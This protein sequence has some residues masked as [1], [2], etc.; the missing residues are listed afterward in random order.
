MGMEAD[1]AVS[2]PGT[3]VMGESTEDLFFYQLE[4]ITLKKGERG[5][6]VLFSEEVPYE[7]IYTWE[8]PSYIDEHNRYGQGGQNQQQQEVW[9]SLKLTNTT[10]QPWTTAPAMTM[11]DNRILGQDKITF[12]P[13]NA[14]A[15]L[16][17]TQAVSVNAEQNEYEVDRQRNAGNFYGH[18]YDLVTVKGTLQVIN[19]KENPVTLKI[20]KSLDGEVQQADKDPKIQKLANGLRQVNPTSQLIWNLEVQPGKDNQVTIEYTYTVF[21]RG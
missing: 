12:T 10:N 20:T 17:I 11:K 8:I 3:P 4:P 5:Y 6:R 1:F 19:Y 18:R 2:A 9:H 16:K 21:V 13:S 14:P 7:H 15:E